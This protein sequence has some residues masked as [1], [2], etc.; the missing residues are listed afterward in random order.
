M[1]LRVAIKHRPST[2]GFPLSSSL[3]RTS[4]PCTLIATSQPF[5]NIAVARMSTSRKV[6]QK[7]LAVETAEVC[8]RHSFLLGARKSIHVQIHSRVQ[9]R[10]YAGL[11]ALLS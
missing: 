10:S 5:R 2:T 1:F 9:A 4:V 8:T 6:V 7:V 3:R 11:L